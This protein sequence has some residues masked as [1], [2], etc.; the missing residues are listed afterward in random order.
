MCDGATVTYTYA[1]TN[2]SDLPLTVNLDDVCSVTSTAAP[3]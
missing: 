3:A 2:N 1:V